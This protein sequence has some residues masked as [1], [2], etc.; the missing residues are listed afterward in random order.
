MV[1]FFDGVENIVGKGKNAGYQH[2]L[3]FLQ[4]FQKTPFSRSLKVRIIWK[5]VKGICYAT[6]FSTWPNYLF[7]PIF[8]TTLLLMT[9]KKRH[10]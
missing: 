5:R 9:L 10:I 7:K 3:F 8:H 4:C 1:S 6:P 2:F